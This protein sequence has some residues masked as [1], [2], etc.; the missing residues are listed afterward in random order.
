[1]SGRW[2]FFRPA[3]HSHLTAIVPAGIFLSVMI[4]VPFRSLEVIE[5]MN[6]FNDVCGA[7]FVATRTDFVYEFFARCW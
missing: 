6:S 5:C 4:S 2:S 3:L 1:M 7:K